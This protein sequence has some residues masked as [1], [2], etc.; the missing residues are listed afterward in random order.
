MH[1][2]DRNYVNSLNTKSY[3]AAKFQVLCERTYNPKQITV[4]KLVEACGIHRNTFY[5]HFDDLESLMSWKIHHDFS[6]QIR[7]YASEGPEAVQ[8]FIS[9]YLT[10]HAHFLNHAYISFG[11]EEFNQLFRSEFAALLRQFI[12]HYCKYHDILISDLFRD[13]CVELFTEYLIAIYSLQ[14]RHPD[15]A[16]R[17]KIL[18]ALK[19]FFDYMVPAT[20]LHSN[21]IL[22]DN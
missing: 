12:P 14:V 8:E 17:K 4:T 10:T 5:Y 20:L 16:D 2:S 22:S 6:E 19:T 9:R 11:A 18:I 15:E 1:E 21:E 3:V 7:I 13:Y